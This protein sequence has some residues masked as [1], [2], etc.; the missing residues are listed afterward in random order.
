MKKERAERDTKGRTSGIL[1]LVDAKCDHGILI[2]VAVVASD[3]RGRIKRKRIFAF[4]DPN[5]NVSRI[6]NT[7]LNAPR[8]LGEERAR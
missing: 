5:E 7:E 3:I 6:E 1:V 4:E 8:V 2:S